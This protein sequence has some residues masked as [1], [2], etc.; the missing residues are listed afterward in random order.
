MIRCLNRYS[1]IPPVHWKIVA[2]GMR[3]IKSGSSI[4]EITWKRT[5]IVARRFRSISLGHFSPVARAEFGSD[6]RRHIAA[7]GDHGLHRP[8]LVRTLFP[9]LRRKTAVW[10]T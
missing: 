2:I 1:L 5:G 4:P 10:L 3:R 8:P 9:R 6:L 7:L